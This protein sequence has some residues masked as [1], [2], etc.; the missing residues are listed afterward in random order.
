MDS[1]YFIVIQIDGT[2]SAT[3]LQ[4][5]RG[6]FEKLKDIKAKPK[7]FYV[8]ELDL[9]QIYLFF[10]APTKTK[11]AKSAVHNWLQNNWFDIAPGEISILPG[12]EPLQ[13]PLQASFTWLNDELNP[14]AAASEMSFQNAV[15]MFLQDL[16]ANANCFE[17]FEAVLTAAESFVPTPTE[18][19][20]QASQEKSVTTS[21]ETLVP[22]ESSFDYAQLE[23]I[24]FSPDG[25][26]AFV[27]IDQ[28]VKLNTEMLVTT[29]PTPLS[30]LETD[31]ESCCPE[32]QTITPDS[33][34]LPSNVIQIDDSIYA[35][36]TVR[37]SV[38]SKSLEE[39]SDAALLGSAGVHEQMEEQEQAEFIVPTVDKIYDILLEQEFR[40]S[41]QADLE[42][43]IRK[44]NN[45]TNSGDKRTVS[46]G[47]HPNV[48]ADTEVRTVSQNLPEIDERTDPLLAGLAP[49]AERPPDAESH[50]PTSTS[51]D[52]E[53]FS[54]QITDQS[55]DQN[56]SFETQK[57]LF[58]LEDDSKE[59]ALPSQRAASERF[60]TRSSSSRDGPEQKRKSTKPKSETD[61]EWKSFEQ[62]TLPFGIN[63]S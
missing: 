45:C 36:N 23:E 38:T 27:L 6:L 60:Q 1:T 44:R 50:V 25:E 51:Q 62:L 7:S 30:E 32:S 8:E 21:I 20:V 9:W 49:L 42:D 31:V 48:Q 55:C 4:T 28:D 11:Q 46:A 37:T 18:T 59:S 26:N 61:S 39:T 19:F 57:F 17:D 2:K 43:A 40:L 58:V 22:T 15:T 14:I 53:H 33:E 56:I 24:D 54:E 35:S 52:L 12:N 16:R 47:T 63:T 13:I 3:A 5:A 41:G 29:D 34:R 10:D